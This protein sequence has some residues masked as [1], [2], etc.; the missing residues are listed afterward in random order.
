MKI[1]LALSGQPRFA[2]LT[3]DYWYK[4]LIDSL[5]IDTFFHTWWSPE[6]VGSLYPSHAKKVLFDE[7][8]TVTDDIP[9]L[10]EEMYKPKDYC[11]NDY[12]DFTFDKTNQYQ[13]YTQYAVSEMVR[14][15]RTSTDTA[16]DVII[17]SRFDL[18]VGQDIEF[19]ID[20]S[21]WVASC[22]PYT[23]GRV[24][25][26]FSVS[27]YENFIKISQTYLNL[28]EFDSQG[29]GEM[30]WALYSQIKKENLSVKKFRADYDTFD[31]VRST[32]KNK[33]VNITCSR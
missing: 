18:A 14:S 1:A 3:Y 7:D 22:C 5:Q 20:N 16:Y 25:D 28:D 31:I 24:N 10:L 13:Y 4:N 11:Y 21:V 17:R 2:K 12:K 9:S 26:M 33:Y 29:R 15:Y 32:T 6:M 30:E 19:S 27:N 23:D 8:M